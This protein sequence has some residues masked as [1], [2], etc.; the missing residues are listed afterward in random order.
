MF[1]SS[2]ILYTQIVVLLLVLSISASSLAAQDSAV[3]S[4]PKNTVSPTTQRADSDADECEKL[5]LEAHA[6]IEKQDP[7]SA[8]I[9]LGEI[10]EFFPT[11]PQWLQACLELSEMQLLAKRFAESLEVLS[12]AERKAKTPDE[13]RAIF[14]AQW[15]YY[16]RQNKTDELIMLLKNQSR[17]ESLQIYELPEVQKDIVDLLKSED[18][19]KS[20]VLIRLL[21]SSQPATDI[22][23]WILRQK[24]SLEKKVVF[25]L[26][27]LCLQENPQGFAQC[28]QLIAS[29]NASTEA[30]VYLSP[31]KEQLATEPWLMP[32]VTFLIQAKQW[33]D[34]LNL[35]AQCK[36]PMDK[37]YII[38]Y[39][40][41][42]R[43]SDAQHIFSKNLKEN[44]EKI[45]WSYLQLLLEGLK[46]TDQLEAVKEILFILPITWET[47][48]AKI[49]FLSI[50]KDRESLYR[51]YLNVHPQLAD[52]ILRELSRIALTNGDLEACT[53][54][55]K[56][57]IEDHPNSQIIDEVK[58]EL[59][60]L[61][62]SPKEIQKIP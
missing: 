43:W 9:L 33:Q 10:V 47:L 60:V 40:G 25:H 3:P 2:K 50:E 4:D 41:L 39:I 48:K 38:C 36:N 31:F 24:I 6:E 7:Q 34:A 45:P 37:E 19:A 26:A 17:N 16:I 56:R 22:S 53:T 18:F 54:Y 12:R 14:K 62:S 21:G 44:A 58:A 35:M 29:L 51:N 57:I 49:D 59:Q 30:I 55:L 28:L 42:K 11:C 61:S 15:N 32:W 52:R 8:A 13:F 27:E 5:L 1:A 20:P 23:S 46:E